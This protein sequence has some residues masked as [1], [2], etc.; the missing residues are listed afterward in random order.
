[1]RQNL[2][3]FDETAIKK[4]NEMHGLRESIQKMKE[5]QEL[6]RK[7]MFAYPHISKISDKEEEVKIAVEVVYSLLTL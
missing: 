5:E 3:I 2:E 6:L 1:M 4:K 7:T